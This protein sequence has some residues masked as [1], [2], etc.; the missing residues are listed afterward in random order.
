M[1]VETIAY[2][3]EDMVAPASRQQLSVELDRHPEDGSAATAAHELR[4]AALGAAASAPGAVA[5]AARDAN[6]N[7]G[8][9]PGLSSAEALRPLLANL[10]QYRLAASV[11]N[12][13]PPLDPVGVAPRAQLARER[14]RRELNRWSD[15]VRRRSELWWWR[16]PVVSRAG[17]VVA[18]IPRIGEGPRYGWCE[19]LGVH[20]CGPSCT[21]RLRNPQLG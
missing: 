12:A 19:Q 3:L 5:V 17:F 16:R 13:A 4:E 1:D 9:D 2:A 6:E 20:P 11:P 14:G 21:K 8:Q 15:E 7:D 18:G 10:L